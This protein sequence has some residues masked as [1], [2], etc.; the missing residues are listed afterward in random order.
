MLDFAR[1]HELL[2]TSDNILILSHRNPDPDTVGSASALGFYLQSKNINFTLAC[3]NSIPEN[4]TFLNSATFYSD[5]N[6]LDLNKF[7]LIMTVDCG[8]LTQTGI[9]DQI[10]ENR[11]AFTLINIDHHQ[12]NPHFG[13]INLVEAAGAT[14]EIILKF[15]KHKNALLDKNISTALLAGIVTDTSYFTNAGTTE[16]SM[17]FASTLLNSNADFKS[18]I[19]STWKKNSPEALKVWGKILSQLHFNEKHKIVTAVI[20]P[21]DDISSDVYEGLA[22]FLT[23]LYEAN[24][25][26]V[27]REN[28]GII[29]CSLRTIKDQI[30]VSQ[31]AKLFGGGGHRK[32][33]GFS[34]R[35]NLIKTDNGWRVRTT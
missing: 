26:F 32:A 34:I 35:G 33:A 19:R 12:T 22:N 27:I 13:D 24:I 29:K 16:Q 23:T 3:P 6:L 4:L 17:A 2:E 8:D 15:L 31:L 18:I 10:I 20:S 28:D 30:D 25:I 1:T 14:A 9:S 11:Q 5:S 7:D 21:E